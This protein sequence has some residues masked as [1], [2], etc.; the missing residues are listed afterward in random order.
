MTVGTLNKYVTAFGNLHRAANGEQWNA[1][2]KPVLLLALLDEI[3]RGAYPHGLI[4]ITPELIAGFRTYWAAL[5][6]SEYWKATLQNPFRYLYHEG[7]WHFVKHGTTVPPEHQS[8]SLRF[9]AEEYDGVRLEL[10]LWQLLQDSHSLNILRNHLLQTYFGKQD[11]SSVVRE[12]TET[13]LY[14]ETEKLKQ[15]AERPFRIRIHERKEEGY[16]LRHTLFPKVI[17][18]IYDE[19]CAICGLSARAGDSVLIDGAHIVPFAVSHND[20][21]G[22]GI[23]LCKNHHWGF[24]RYWFT[25]SYEFRVIVS[26][27]LKYSPGYITNDVLIRLPTAP[28]LHPAPEAVKWHREKC[29]ALWKF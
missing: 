12:S 10:D 22:N 14:A 24:D 21:P 18:G 16:Y 15:E 28:I 2:H 20:H 25:L 26:P 23:S 17:R 3:S 1:P 7:W 27:Q 6:T 8:P 13:Y 9:L 5:V 19:Q 11:A 4:T 29:L